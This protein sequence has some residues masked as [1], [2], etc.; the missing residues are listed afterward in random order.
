MLLPHID[1]LQSHY[2]PLSKKKVWLCLSTIR[3][4]W[5]QVKIINALKLCDPKL[6]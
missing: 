2:T 1:L 4:K 6:P 3:A 5:G